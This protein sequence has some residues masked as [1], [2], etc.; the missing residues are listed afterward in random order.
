MIYKVANACL[1][2][3]LLISI[4]QSEVQYLFC[5]TEH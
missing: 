5:T 3:N 1:Q 4:V 2:N